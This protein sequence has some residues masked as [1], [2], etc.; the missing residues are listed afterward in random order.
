MN[1]KWNHKVSPWN[2]VEAQTKLYDNFLKFKHNQGR[3]IAKLITCKNLQSTCRKC[4]WRGI[5]DQAPVVRKP[6]SANPRLNHP[7]LR[8]KFILRLNSVPQ[9]SISTIQGLYNTPSEVG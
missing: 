2:K 9:S 1:E 8:K 4:F 3:N 6:I 7:K 5:N